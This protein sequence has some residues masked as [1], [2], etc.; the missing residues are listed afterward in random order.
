VDAL[1]GAK[2]CVHLASTAVIQQYW[3]LKYADDN[4]DAQWLAE[5]LRLNIYLKEERA[6]RDLMRKRM[7]LVQQST[8]N[9]LSIQGIYMRHLSYR[10]SNNKIKQLTCEQIAQEHTANTAQAVT[11]TLNV[12]NCLRNEIKQIESALLVQVKLRSE[13]KSLSSIDGIGNTL[14]LSIMLETGDI[15]RFNKLGN[16]ALY[17]RSAL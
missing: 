2:F 14:A 1:I 10:L 17:R 13:F 5:M 16:Y 9:L 3:G 7:S 4:S 8:A 11:A 15:K 12:M 6:V